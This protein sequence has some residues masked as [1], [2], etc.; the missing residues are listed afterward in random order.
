MSRTRYKI[1]DQNAVHFL[2]FSVVNWLPILKESEAKEVIINSLHFLQEKGTLTVFAYVIMEDHIHLI[3]QAENLSAEISRFKSY[4]ARQIINILEKNGTNYILK[5][6]R[7]NK[8]NHHKDSTYQFWQEG[9][10]PQKIQGRKMMM[11]KIDYIHNNP[12][13]RGYVDHPFQWRYSSVNN[14]LSKKGVLNVCT[15]W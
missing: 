2:T 8:L 3:A 5:E 11:Q 13:R 7:E 15:N 12:V 4:T 9:S 14:Y 6:L 1:I 10:H